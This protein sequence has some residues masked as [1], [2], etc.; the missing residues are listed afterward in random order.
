[1]TASKGKSLCSTAIYWVMT[2]ILRFMCP[3][4]PLC[5]VAEQEAASKAGGPS[6]SST[7]AGE[8]PGE[9]GCYMD[10]NANSD[11]SCIGLWQSRAWAYLS[12]RGN[13]AGRPTWSNIAGA[14]PSVSS[15][16]KIEKPSN[17]RALRKKVNLSLFSLDDALKGIWV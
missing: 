1:M 17:M 2:L 15:Q 16:T 14:P 5:A 10:I 11:V 7:Q 9:I 13:F 12:Q 6:G 4:A 3:Y 8:S